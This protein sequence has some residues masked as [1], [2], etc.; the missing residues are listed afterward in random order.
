MK[1]E[2]YTNSGKLGRQKTADI[3]MVPKTKMAHMHINDY[4]NA[5][6]NGAFTFVLLN[7]KEADMLRDLMS[8][9]DG[10]VKALINAAPPVAKKR[11]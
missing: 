3:V 2:F 5:F 4:T 9:M 1:M 11:K 10:Q 7:M 8:S 6:Q